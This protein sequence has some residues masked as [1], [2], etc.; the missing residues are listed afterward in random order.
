MASVFI[1]G[2]INAVIPIVSSLYGQRDFSGMGILMKTA[3][4]AQFAMNVVL[5]LVFEAFP[6]GI[7]DMYNVAGEAWTLAITGLRIRFCF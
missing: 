7:L 6:Q 1:G 2:V 4:R 5:L 3:L